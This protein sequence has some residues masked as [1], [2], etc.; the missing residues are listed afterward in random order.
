M[1]DVNP[2][3]FQSV[4]V[5]H[6]RDDGWTVEELGALE[7]RVKPP[8]EEGAGVFHLSN[9]LQQ[10][11]DGATV[12]QV[13][14]ALIHSLREAGDSLPADAQGG[15]APAP[16]DMTRLMPLLKP[17]ALLDDVARS[18]VD[19]IAWRPFIGDELIVALVL[20]F[21]QSVRYVRANEA[22]ASGR[23]FDDLL[24]TALGNLYSR[25]GGD[26]YE[27]GDEQTGTIFILATQD[28]YDATRILLKPLLE[29]LAARVNGDL[30]I[31]IPNRDFCIAFGGA[32]RALVAQIGQQV[33]KDAQARA[34][35][36]SD[37]LFAFRRGA[38][39][40]YEAGDS[41]AGTSDE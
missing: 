1:N 21:P 26:A 32:N 6:L 5:T 17:R 15:A 31:G 30:I 39:E 35:P 11:R 2:G 33:R 41:E 24:E 8:G 19:A 16:L 3:E 4:L 37:R 40:V 25:T 18:K 12:G 38:L 7:I 22:D 34:Y 23:S 13:A 9:M 10:Y 36:L 28:G 20:D 14:E 29:R 27:I